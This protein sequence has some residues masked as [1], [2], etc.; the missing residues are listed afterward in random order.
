MC[1][2]TI[3]SWWEPDLLDKYLYQGINGGAR[4]QFPLHIVGYASLGQSNSSGD[5]KN[6]LNEMFGARRHAH[7]EDRA[8][9]RRALFEVRQLICLGHLSH[10]SM[11]PAI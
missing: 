10:R 1:P 2:R 9:N 3:P 8:R 11:S 6:S 5:K 4:V 7:L